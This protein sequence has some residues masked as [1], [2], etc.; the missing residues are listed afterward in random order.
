[1]HNPTFPQFNTWTGV[2][3]ARVGT[4]TPACGRGTGPVCHC[5]PSV[6]PGSP[7]ALCPTAAAD[8]AG[9]TSSGPPCL[10][11]CSGGPPSP[12]GFDPCGPCRSNTRG[13][14]GKAAAGSPTFYV[15]LQQ[16]AA[17]RSQ[18]AVHAATSPRGAW[19]DNGKAK[20]SF[21][22]VAGNPHIPKE[23]TN[24]V[25]QSIAA[26]VRLKSTV[27][28]SRSGL[29]QLCRLHKKYLS[30]APQHKKVN[31]LSCFPPCPVITKRVCAW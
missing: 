15:R 14:G 1:M 4:G 6:F 12:A 27:S 3:G 26:P 11:S 13:P 31:S 18:R 2:C 23:N 17:W 9:S 24:T 8:A 20:F 29:N 21:A 5:E 28:T 22:V 16:A 10:W 7:S 25:D 30:S 19:V